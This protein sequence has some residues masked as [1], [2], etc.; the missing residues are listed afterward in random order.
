MNIGRPSGL[1]SALIS[2]IAI[3]NFSNAHATTASL[4]VTNYGTDSSSCGSS[5]TPCRSIS[6]AIANASDGETIWVGAGHYGNV[7]GDPGFAEPGDEHVQALSNYFDYPSCMVCV[8]KAVH[9]FSLA[10][11]AATTIDSGPSPTF[12][13]TVMIVADGVVFG[14]PG[15]G[16]TITGKNATGLVV[17]LENWSTSRLGVTVAGNVDLSDGVGF[18]VNGTEYNPFRGCPGPQYCP[19]FLGQV[20]LSGNQAIGSGTGF[21]VEPK[22]LGVLGQPLRFVLQNNV[23]RG[24]GTGYVIDPGYGLFCDDCTANNS[25]GIVST[26]ENFAAD[27]ATGFS[28]TR[29]GPVNSNVATNN[30]QF[31]FLLFEAG[32]FVNNSAIGNAGPGVIVID[33]AALYGAT[34]VSYGTFRG[35]NLFGNDRNRPSLSF[36]GYGSPDAYNPGPSAHCGVLNMGAVAQSLNYESAHAPPSPPIPTVT[37]QAAENYWGSANGPNGPGDV[38]GGVCDQND[39]VTVAKPFLTSPAAIPSSS[40]P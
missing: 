1:H 6:Q 36:G 29:S 19:P 37:L 21:W 33:E 5:T 10:G 39:G 40:A 7:N 34:P 8:T 32:Q 20:V 4:L 24:A 11:S 17:D 13:A 15:H 9:I 23:A 18:R 3:L 38:V 27:C 2:L 28:F 12:T 22:T 14:S 30:S 16:F 25:A 26:V 35:N 31:G